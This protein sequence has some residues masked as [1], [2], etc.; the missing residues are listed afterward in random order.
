VNCLTLKAVLF[1]LHDTLVYLRNPINS[2]DVSD[3]LLKHGYAIYPQSWDA[4]SRYVGMVDYPKHGY[5]NRQAF[6][7]QILRRLSVEIDSGTLKEL[8]QL[9]DCRN[10]N[11]LFSDS[12]LAVK[13][14]KQLCLKTAIVTTIP[15][16][17]FSTAIM[18][19]RDHFDVI[20]TGRRAACEKSNPSMYKQTLEELETI[21]EQ[22][23]MIGDELL[24]DVK[25][26]KKLGM[27]TILLDRSND[28]KKK[29]PEADKKAKTLIEAMTAI[30]K[31]RT[32]A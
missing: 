4:A 8:A 23:V 13:K 7:K 1:D 15:D 22:A 11:F 5:T 17:A 3:F 14:A 2:E 31:W 25:I 6:L 16:F 24:V 9:Y 27:C 21:P 10:H 19:I 20:M 26:P 30:E 12:A 18:P 29:P 28:F 32:Q